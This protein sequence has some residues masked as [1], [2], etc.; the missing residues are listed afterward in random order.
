MALLMAGKEW[1]EPVPLPAPP[2]SPVAEAAQALSDAAAWKPQ[3]PDGLDMLARFREDDTPLLVHPLGRLEL[4]QLRVPL[5]TTIDRIGPS[6]VTSRRV[7]LE[8]PTFGTLPTALLIALP[9]LPKRPPAPPPPLPNKSPANPAG[10]LM[11]SM[12]CVIVS[13]TLETA[14]EMSSNQPIA[15]LL[16][17]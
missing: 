9:R 14:S 13:P 17:L 3:L 15:L 1:G 6:P 12:V 10:S 11:S 2:I 8:Q 4:K 7:H 5:E 16:L